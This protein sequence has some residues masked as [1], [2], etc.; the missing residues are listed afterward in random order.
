MDFVKVTRLCLPT[1]F[2]LPD[3]R[4]SLY[5]QLS[6]KVYKY[7]KT[8]SSTLSSVM[9]S[10]GSENWSTA[11]RVLVFCR[12]RFSRKGERLW[13]LYQ[14]ISESLE[15]H[16]M[17]L[18]VVDPDPSPPLDGHYI[19]ESGNKSRFSAK[20]LWLSLWLDRLSAFEPINRLVF[21]SFFFFLVEIHS[22]R[23]SF[24]LPLFLANF[25]FESVGNWR[26]VRHIFLALFAF[27]SLSVPWKWVGSQMGK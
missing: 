22:P 5:G 23:A 21:A 19:S 25:V 16:P 12:S 13:V 6:H 4:F 14:L 8:G 17:F 1:S 24:F 7:I 10:S 20:E 11:S 26:H 3:V 18:C 9:F 27:M 15:E 2:Q